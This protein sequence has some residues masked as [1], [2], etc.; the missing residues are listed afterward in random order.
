M[1]YPALSE[2]DLETDRLHLRALDERDEAL[3]RALYTDP[4][5]MRFIAEPLSTEQ[6]VRCFRRTIEGMRERPMRWMSLT[7]LD[8]S[9]QH[10]LGICGV[11]RFEVA[12]RRLEVGILLTGEARAQGFAREGLAALMRRLFDV[13]WVDE[14]WVRFSADCAA[15]RRLNISLGFAPRA[16]AENEM[17]HAS[18]GKH[19]WSV[20]RSSWCI[21]GAINQQGAGNVKCHRFSCEHGAGRTTASCF[22]ERGANCT[23]P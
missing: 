7:M 19:V 14:L 11:P 12:A 10:A 6:A 23:G 21:P 13:T 4:Q 18:R 17:T 22:A 1:P 16:V 2:F 3:F 15:V 20:Y 8:R 5:T 9:S